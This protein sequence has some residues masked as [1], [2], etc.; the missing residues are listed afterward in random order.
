[1]A[2]RTPTSTLVRLETLDSPGAN[3]VESIMSTVLNSRLKFSTAFAGGVTLPPAAPSDFPLVRRV[4]SSP[5]GE[6]G[7][8]PVVTQGRIVGVDNLPTIPGCYVVP[9]DVAG[10]II[11]LRL[12]VE[13]VRFFRPL[14][15]KDG[16]SP[17]L[18]EITQG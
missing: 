10:A 1:M 14:P 17:G 3:G 12:A 5:L 4:A 9:G 15:M 2:A 13:G 7:G 6:I 18:E 8:V 16:V 11:E